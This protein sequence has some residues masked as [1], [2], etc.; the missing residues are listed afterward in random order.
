M[1]QPR[2]H[3]HMFRVGAC[4]HFEWAAM[5]GGSWNRIQFPA[6]CALIGHPTRGWML[7]DT[8][9][10]DHFI[11][12]TRPF[13]ERFYRAILP[14]DLSIDSTLAEQLLPL[15][16]APADIRTILISHFHGDHIAGLR[17]FPGAKFFAM[18]SDVE[19]AMGQSRLRGVLDGFLRELLPPDFASRLSFADSSPAVSLPAW[20]APLTVGFDL[21][22]DSSVIAVP[23]PGH[24]K[25]Q[26]GI[27]LR[28]QNDAVRFLVADA[29]WS[30]PACREGRLPSRLAGLL[31]AD[32]P[33]YTETFLQLR[34][35]ALREPSL[36]LIPS[37][38][39]ATWAQLAP[40]FQ[41][42]NGT[43]G[44]ASCTH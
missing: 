10:A 44:G 3:F 39:A 25:C 17:N 38:C 35:I 34:Q 31:F 14:V 19:R 13:P 7:Y 5:R 6:L 18:K 11:H 36:S 21:F 1:I 12:E 41:G 27:V 28:D 32:R 40:A 2:V 4:R 23:L 9:Y 15:G 20:L 37:H 16:I 42:K 8:G 30:M 22:G 33:K 29:C 43:H 26:M 24:A